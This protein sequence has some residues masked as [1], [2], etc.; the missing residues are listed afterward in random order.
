MRKAK[1]KSKIVLRPGYSM[2]LTYIMRITAK[3]TRTIFVSKDDFRSA[4][5]K[6]IL[7]RKKD[8]GLTFEDCIE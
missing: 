4:I 2:T 1:P 7:G 8:I 6:A 5:K 3:T